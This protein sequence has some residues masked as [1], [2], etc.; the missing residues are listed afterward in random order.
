MLV[1]VRALLLKFLTVLWGISHLL[2]L[3]VMW[4]ILISL[5]F[6]VLKWFSVLRFLWSCV[7]IHAYKLCMP[8]RHKWHKMPSCVFLYI[9]TSNFD[10]MKIC[11]KRKCETELEKPQQIAFTRLLVLYK[12]NFCLNKCICNM[13]GFMKLFFMRCIHMRLSKENRNQRQKIICHPLFCQIAVRKWFKFW[14]IFDL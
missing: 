12:Y 10:M 5:Q 8:L 4:Y 2:K 11:V 7:C 13:N 14:I 6:C 1:S 3:L 9:R